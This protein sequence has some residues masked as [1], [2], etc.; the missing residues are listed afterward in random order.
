MKKTTLKT[1]IILTLIIIWGQ[2]FLPPYASEQESGFIVD[3]L[4][5]I[6]G[7]GNINE[8]LIRKTAHFLEYLILA[9]EL[10]AF[11]GDW[12]L[13]Y[14]LGTACIDETIQIF[15]GRGSSLVDVWIDFAGFIAGTLIMKLIIKKQRTSD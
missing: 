8:E 2:S 14:G 10:T 4:E 6:V 7:S 5:K 1:L 11:F 15:S 3:I 9:L 12:K 13:L